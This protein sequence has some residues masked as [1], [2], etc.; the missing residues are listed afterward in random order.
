M[1]SIEIEKEVKEILKELPSES[2]ELDYKQRFYKVDKKIDF[3]KD[4]IAMLN[5][6]ESIGENKYIIF[7]VSDEKKLIGVDDEQIINDNIFQDWVKNYIFP[8]P[9]I[10]TGIVEFENKKFGYICISKNNKYCIYE[11][12]ENV[13]GNFQIKSLTKNAVL[14]GQAFFRR[15]SKNEVMTQEDRE[16]ILLNENSVFYQQHILN[17]KNRIKE[18]ENRIPNL[19]LGLKLLGSITDEENK[20]E[21]NEYNFSKIIKIK[22]KNVQQIY[23]SKKLYNFD[24]FSEDDRK[25]ISKE[26]IDNYNKS[27]IDKSAEIDKY[28][29]D[30]FLYS[31]VFDNGQIFDFCIKNEGTV[32]AKNINIIIEFP[33][34]IFIK[35]KDKA[36]DIISEDNQKKMIIALDIPENPVEKI[37]MEKRKQELANNKI[38]TPFLANVEK[39]NKLFYYLNLNTEKISN[40]EKIINIHLENYNKLSEEKKLFSQAILNSV[41]NNFET[42]INNTSENP[43]V[44]IKEHKIEIEI[45]EGLLHTFSEEIDN[46]CIIPTKTGKF[47]VKVSIF[48]KEYLKW[49]EYTITFEVEDK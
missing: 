24:E 33:E 29:I 2:V 15:G 47:D 12:N 45:K 16:K 38:L 35:F 13:I 41:N 9:I 7:G 22:G 10:K 4:V 8:K 14:K 25:Y 34:Y 5:S 37:E 17:L 48:C 49:Q 36:K 43:K 42:S 26:Y 18:F 21:K 20:F 1:N 31:S 40:F 32:E 6:L 19:K 39:T 28:N 46:I 23:F 44:D 27:I 11:A 30:R 3:V